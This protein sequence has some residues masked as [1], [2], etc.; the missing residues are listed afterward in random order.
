MGPLVYLS[1]CGAGPSPE[2]VSGPITQVWPPVARIC[3]ARHRDGPGRLPGISCAVAVRRRPAGCGPGRTATGRRPANAE[4]ARRGPGDRRQPPPS[5]RLRQRQAPPRRQLVDLRLPCRGYVGGS[6]ARPAGPCRRLNQLHD[7]PQCVGHMRCEF[8]GRAD[9]P[10][11]LYASSK[12]PRDNAERVFTCQTYAVT[13]PTPTWCGPSAHLVGQPAAGR[14]IAPVA[15]DE[16]L[17]E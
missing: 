14:L 10:A 7:Q 17:Q 12:S 3:P 4:R 9:T 1:A 2:F 11:H 13:R 5:R 15:G 16:G 6:L 8:A